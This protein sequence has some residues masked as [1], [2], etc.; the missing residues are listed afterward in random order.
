MWVESIKSNG[1]GSVM[2]YDVDRFR[3]EYEYASVSLSV[4]SLNS[5]QKI[6]DYFKEWINNANREYPNKVKRIR[7]QERIGK[8][9]EIKLEIQRKEKIQKAV[10]EFKF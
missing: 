4:N 2:G 6:I 1:W 7:E 9:N 8:E 5:V 3:F 10:S